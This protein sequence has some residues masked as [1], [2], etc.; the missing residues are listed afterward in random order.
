VPARALKGAQQEEHC[1]R[2]AHRLMDRPHPPTAIVGF[3]DTWALPAAQ[4][5]RERGLQPGAEVSVA[6]YGDRAYRMGRCAT[7]TSCRIDARKMGRTALRLALER[8]RP[9]EARTVI[10]RDRPVFRESTGPAPDG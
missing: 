4:A 8:V 5:L 1:R 3:D 9:D 2:A 7:L 10:V 6:G